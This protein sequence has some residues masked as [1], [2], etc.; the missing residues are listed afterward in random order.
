MLEVK[1][2]LSEMGGVNMIPRLDKKF[3]LMLIMLIVS[4][5]ILQIGY[6]QASNVDELVQRMNQNNTVT[7]LHAIKALGEAKD[8][9]AVDPLIAVLKDEKCGITAANALA[10]IGQ[11]SVAP[12]FTALK[13]DN[14]VARRNAAMAL[15]KIKDSTAVKPLIAAL[16]DENPIVRRNAAK[17]LGEIQDNRAVEPL[18][19]ALNDNSPVVRRNAALALKGMGSS[20]TVVVDILHE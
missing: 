9:R 17:A 3:G 5:C 7:R 13:D 18:T 2:C 15:G 6:L 11:P 14:P 16:N 8:A 1:F 20:E 10:K 19:A 12:L 4:I